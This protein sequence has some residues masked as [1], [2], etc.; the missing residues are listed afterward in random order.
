MIE[1]IVNGRKIEFD[2]DEPGFLSYEEVCVLAGVNP[3][4]KPSMT[5]RSPL[6]HGHIIS[7]GGIGPLE[8]GAIY[9]CAVTGDA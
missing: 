3:S 8:N 2:R 5:C 1:I 9:N 7:P 4:H 6:R